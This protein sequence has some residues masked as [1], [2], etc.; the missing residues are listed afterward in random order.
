MLVLFD[1][2]YIYY[3]ARKVKSFKVTNMAESSVRGMMPC[4]LSRKKD[5]LPVLGDEGVGT[6]ERKKKV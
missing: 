3:N 5:G 6:R 2:S 4:Q 1:D